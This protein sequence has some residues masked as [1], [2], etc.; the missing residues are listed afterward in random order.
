M[1]KGRDNV[2]PQVTLYLIHAP[3]PVAHS[4][5]YLGVT[6]RPS[7]V[8]RMAEH[9]TAKLKV[10]R[11]GTRCDGHILVKLFAQLA[12]INTPEEVIEKLVVASWTGTR[13]EE[14]NLKNRKKLRDICPVCRAAKGLAPLPRMINGTT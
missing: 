8:P 12:G 10:D 9:L 1:D 2:K 7:L 5:H 13:D 14:R 11:G 4:R 3:V 6:Q